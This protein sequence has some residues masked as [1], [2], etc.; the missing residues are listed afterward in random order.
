MDLKKRCKLILSGE[1]SLA[2]SVARVVIKLPPISAWE[3]MIPILLVF[4][5]AK[6]KESREIFVQNFMF[7]KQLA[8]KAAR[9]MIKEGQSR[10]EIMSRIEEETRSLLA[11]VK[12]GLYSEQVRL[13]QL[14]EIDLLIDHYR[15]VLQADGDNHASWIIH[16]YGSRE[17]YTAFLERLKG[18]EKA[19]YTAAVQTVGTRTSDE[20]ASTMEETTE[21]LRLAAAGKI[22]ESGDTRD[23]AE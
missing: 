20:V 1:R 9:D 10:E 14:A 19:V 22:F 23:Y 8:L 15:R 21:R 4:S 12:E 16:S 18:A 5:F 3:V 2:T 13:M 17:N 7:T 6:S 11:S